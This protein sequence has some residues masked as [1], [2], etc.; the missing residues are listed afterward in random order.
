MTGTNGAYIGL[1]TMHTPMDVRPTVATIPLPLLSLVGKGWADVAYFTNIPAPAASHP[2]AAHL[3]F[4]GSAHE[5]THTHNT[6]DSTL[7]RWLSVESA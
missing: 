1:A 5:Y 4:S 6:P 3:P 2:T 7:V